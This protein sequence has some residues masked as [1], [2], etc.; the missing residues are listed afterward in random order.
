MIFILFHLFSIS[1]KTHDENKKYIKESTTENVKLFDSKFQGE[2]S[3]TV[4]TEETTSGTASITYHFSI[5]NDVAILTTT[6]YH[7]PIRCNGN[8]KALENNGILELYYSGDEESCKS[9]N[10]KFKIKRENNKFYIQGLGG[11]ATF[12]EWIELSKTKSEKK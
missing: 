3:S 1:C 6:T 12:N 2:F 7:E 8:Y 9:K 11:E 5:K 4:E 10:A